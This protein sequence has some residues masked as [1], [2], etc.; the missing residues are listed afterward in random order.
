MS[1]PASAEGDSFFLSPMPSS[2]LARTASVSNASDSVHLES[3]EHSSEDVCLESV[4]ADT[5]GESPCVE[6]EDP[7]S[8][9]DEPDLEHIESDVD[10]EDPGGHAD[11]QNWR[12]G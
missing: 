9:S 11:Q 8:S 12:L 4:A 5:D 7:H 3:L 2:P 6:L 10:L 1:A